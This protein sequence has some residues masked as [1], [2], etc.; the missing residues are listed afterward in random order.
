MKLIKA[1]L[2]VAFPE[3]SEEEIC[4]IARKNVFHIVWNWVDFI[5]ILKHSD[6]IWGFMEGEGFPKDELPSQMIFCLPHIGSWELVAQ[7]GPRS[8]PKCAAIA[9]SF[10]YDKINEV[11][12]HSRTINGLQIIQRDGA[13]RGTMAAV[14]EAISVGILIDQNL[15]PR[16]GGEFVEFFGLPVPTSPMPAVLAKRYGVTLVTGACIRQPSG[17]FRLY[18]E[19]LELPDTN[20]KRELTQV[21]LK[22]NEKLIRQYPEQYNWLYRRWLYIPGDVSEELKT[23]YPYY[24]VQKEYRMK[25]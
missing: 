25:S 7:V 14:R 12:E 9:E 17:K 24:A 4:L 16:H 8:F 10:P 11:L 3:K 19:I 22:A 1:N 18:H 21:I 5:R 20:D 15:S 2:K 13:V 23:K 6:N